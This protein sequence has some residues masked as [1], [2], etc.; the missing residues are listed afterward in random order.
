MDLSLLFGMCI[1]VMVMIIMIILTQ[2]SENSGFGSSTKPD[3]KV[4]QTSERS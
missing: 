4:S 2:S 3:Q 1:I